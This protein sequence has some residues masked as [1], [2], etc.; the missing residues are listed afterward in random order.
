MRSIRQDLA[1]LAERLGAVQH[2]CRGAPQRRK[3]ARAA[4]EAE[5]LRWQ[6]FGART[7]RRLVLAI[8][9]VVFLLGALIVLHIVAW[10]W[11]S[12]DHD[13]AIHW[14]ALAVGGFD[15]VV[16]IFMLWLSRRSTPS[17]TEVEAFEV[18]QRAIAGLK[19]PLSVAQ[20]ALPALRFT[21][22]R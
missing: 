14:A 21:A 12:T 6:T 1:P 2:N 3:P 17:R 8:L 9:A 15:L 13:L 19:S 20:L 5:T 4:A 7:A 18:R 22:R 16:T 10:H 11:L